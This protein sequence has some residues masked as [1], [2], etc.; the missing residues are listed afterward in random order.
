MSDAIDY[1]GWTA[2]FQPQAWIND[3]AVDIDS[4]G[5]QQWQVDPDFLRQLVAGAAKWYKISELEALRRTVEI[6]TN[7]SDRLIEDP[8]A[9]EWIA[10]HSGPFYCEAWHRTFD[11]EPE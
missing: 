2:R 10:A 8:T 11:V 9:P 4:D 5:D 6:S 7:E 1:E 3:Y